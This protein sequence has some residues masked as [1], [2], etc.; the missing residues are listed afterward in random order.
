[1]SFSVWSCLTLLLGV[2]S[3]HGDWN[4]QYGDYRST[5]YV[6]VVYSIG[7]NNTNEPWNY[8]YPGLYSYMYSSP[9]VSESGIV[10]VPFLKYVP[11]TDNTSIVLDLQVRAAAPNG[12][13]IWI[14]HGLGQDKAC[15]SILLTNAVY[16]SKRQIVVIGWTCAAG[17]PYYEKHGQ[18]IGINSTTGQVVWRSDKLYDANDLSSLSVSLNVAYVSGGYNCYKDGIPLK[19]NAMVDNGKPPNRNKEVDSSVKQNISRIYAFSL[20]DGKMIWTKAYLQVGCTSQT[21]IFPIDK[22]KHLVIFATNL[23]RNVYLGGKLLA[24]ECDTHGSCDEKWLSDV[25]VCWGSTF[26]FSDQGVLFGGYGFA[27]VPDLIFGLDV[28]T[29]KKIFSNKGYCGAGVYPSGPAV[30][31][32]GDAYYRFV[33]MQAS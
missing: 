31:E 22:N 13:F 6:K 19:P 28:K 25:E 12:S 18:L 20:N 27:G 7:G 5:N 17:F 10:F 33:T 15:G 16:L 24:Y 32:K 1:M 9:A 29:G 14:A 11:P 4:Q 21:K 30:D 8:S 2:Y 23:P 26:A 3:V